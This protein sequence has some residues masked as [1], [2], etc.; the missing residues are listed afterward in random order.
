MDRKAEPNSAVE[1]APEDARAIDALIGARALG[2]RLASAKQ[3]GQI[4][5]Q[6][7]KCAES[8]MRLIGQCPAADPPDDLVRRT[9]GR[10]R[11]YEEVDPDVMRLR[12]HRRGFDTP[13][14]MKEILAVAAMLVI[15]ASVILPVLAKTRH[16]ALRVACRARISAVGKAFVQYAAD[17]LGTMPRG[18]VE[19]GSNWYHVGWTRYDWQS[20]KA[21]SANL[22][23][24][25]RGRYVEPS[26][27]ACPANPDASQTMTA[28]A[29]DW[30]TAAAVSYSYQNQFGERTGRLKNTPRMAILADKNPR[31]E[32]RRG[33]VLTY[34]KSLRMSASSDMH[35]RRG[36]N[37]LFADGSVIWYISPRMPNGDHI[38]LADGVDDYEGNEVPSRQNDAFL[39]P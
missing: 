39:V 14:R 38:W 8:L 9:L 6:R 29:R 13:V 37:V 21:N 18:R 23:V 25:A 36:Q 12:A 4:D 11:R 1:L 31:F 34:D 26:T 10:I 5:E 24:L 32:I 17:N 28:D 16:E 20:V 22:Y 35:N 2:P 3:V 19:P 7:A 15:G 27:L 30:P 33:M